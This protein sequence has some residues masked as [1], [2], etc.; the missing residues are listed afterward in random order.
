[1]AKK[2]RKRRKEKQLAN[3][4]NVVNTLV[5]EK[6]KNCRKQE[7]KK[8]QKGYHWGVHPIFTPIFS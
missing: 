5:G 1:M 2:R 6:L 4:I 3:N 7:K 8:K